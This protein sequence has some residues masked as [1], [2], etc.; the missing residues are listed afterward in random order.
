MHI[1]QTLFGAL[2]VSS[3]YIGS[4]TAQEDFVPK[5]EPMPVPGVPGIT[6]SV[7]ATAEIPLLL[8]DGISP[9]K[10]EAVLSRIPDKER[11][12]RGVHDIALFKNISPSVVLVATDDAIGSG[13]LLSGGYILTNWH[14]VGGNKTVGVI[15]KPSSQLK[16]STPGSVYPPTVIPADVMRIDQV[17]DLALLRPVSLPGEPRKPIE[18]GDIKDIVV[19]ADVHAIGHP[20]GEEWSY[21]KGLV[22]QVRD[23]YDWV[24]EEKIKHHADV[25]QTQTP[26]NPGNSGGPLLSDD[27]KLIG[28][29]SFKAEG[30]ALNFAVSVS[31]VRRFL[32]ATSSVIVRNEPSRKKEED[33]KSKVV[34]EGRNKE[35]NAK[36]KQVSFKC[37]DV[38][39]LAFILPDDRRKPMMAFYDSKRRNKP[40]AIIVDPSRTENWKFSFWDSDLNDT[41]ALRGIHN[42]GNLKPVRF[43]KRCPRRAATE[44]RCV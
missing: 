11:R 44:F 14:V 5:I 15:F 2:I 23:G 1:L 36:I 10:T 4:V 24:T 37:D 19:G 29:N 39:D 40:D 13:S 8:S 35:D 25:I 30:E 6:P 9:K 26:I 3:F 31:D 34:F 43:V 22:S 38:V 7:F 12:T 21:T 16:P 32:A 41:F 17:R 18:L 27:G 28:V 42:N 33:C 20:K